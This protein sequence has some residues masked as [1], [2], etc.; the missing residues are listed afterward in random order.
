MGSRYHSFLLR[1]WKTGSRKDQTYRATLED[2][3][4]RSVIGFSSV[5]AL[6]DF[7]LGLGQLDNDEVK[8]E[9]NRI[10]PEGKNAK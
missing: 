2:V 10:H 8:R 3:K 5:R 6:C 1:I 4:T 9:D 7:L